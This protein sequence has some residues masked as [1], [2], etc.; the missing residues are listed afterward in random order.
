MTWE[1]PTTTRTQIQL[2]VVVQTV[3]CYHKLAQSHQKMMKTHD[4]QSK[5]TNRQLY[6]GR[7]RKLGVSRTGIVMN[8]WF[9]DPV[10]TL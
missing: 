8:T 9:L 4:L 5:Q 3:G 2:V 10:N 1:L 6:R 7:W